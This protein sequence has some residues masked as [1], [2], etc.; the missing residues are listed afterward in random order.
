MLMDAMLR[1]ETRPN[2]M[3]VPAAIRELEKIEMVRRSGGRYRLD[4]AVTK[5]QRTILAALGISE[6]NIREIAADIGNRLTEA[7]KL[8]TKK[9]N[10]STE[11][12][13]AEDETD[14]LD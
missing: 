12:C 13:D 14:R 5:R 8:Q 9:H 2:F 1:M 10:D 6:D 4:H 11:E 7:D 3:T